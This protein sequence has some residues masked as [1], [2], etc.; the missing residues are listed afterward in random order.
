MT[1]PPKTPL[2]AAAAP[3]IPPLVSESL[4]TWIVRA[5]AKYRTSGISVAQTKLDYALD[6]IPPD[7]LRRMDITSVYSSDNPWDMFLTRLR[8]VLGE[9]PQAV[10]SKLVSDSFD[11]SSALARHSDMVRAF[12]SV[13]DLP[14]TCIRYGVLRLIPESEREGFL[15]THRNA[16]T[17]DFAKEADL[18]ISRKSNAASEIHALRKVQKKK[19]PLC[20][21]HK[22]FGSKALRCDRHAE[23]PPLVAQVVDQPLSV[24]SVS[25]LGPLSSDSD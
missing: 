20:Y 18:L 14:A 22:K 15:S 19:L 4:E 10:V 6:A 5:E 12:S 1:E 23:C 8:A 11:S 16:S 9:D 21:Y 2:V 3:R 13:A 7:V 24:A 25:M 17:Y